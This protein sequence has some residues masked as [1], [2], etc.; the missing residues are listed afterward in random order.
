MYRRRI[1]VVYIL[2]LSAYVIHIVEETLGNFAAI[3]VL[4]SHLLY[5]VLNGVI[6]G[7]TI[8]LLYCIIRRKRSAFYG[9]IIFA[10]IMFLN[11][12]AH[13]VGLIITGRYYGDFAGSYSGIA[14]LAIGPVLVYYLV[15]ELRENEETQSV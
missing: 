8:A 7:V 1:I 5:I 9:G 10:G 4:G 3:R 14:L 6:V 15:K 13:N 11:G 12:C 2:L